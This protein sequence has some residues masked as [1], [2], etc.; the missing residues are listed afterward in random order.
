MSQMNDLRERSAA[1]ARDNRDLERTVDMLA[2]LIA[3]VVSVSALYI[4]RDIFVPIA[5][6]V[7]LSFVLS[8]PVLWLRRVGLP[9]VAA[10]M[11]VVFASLFIAFAVS[12]ALTRQV[13]DLAVDLPR[14]QTTIG[15]KINR[16]RDM[17]SA[18]AI[19]E[20]AAA[21]LKSLATLGG[22]RAN[23]T[24]KPSSSELSGANEDHPIPVEVREPAP[25]PFALVRTIVGTALSPLETAAIVV[26]FV[27]F[28][29]LQREDLRDRFVRL[30][31][32]GDLQRTTVAMDD[33]ARRLS[34]YFLA[35][36]TINAAFGLAV[37]GGLYAIGVPSPILF[38]IIGF[39]MRFVPYVGP[40][41]AGGFPVALAAAVDPGWALAL[42]TLA[43][44]IVLEMLVGNLIEPLLYG[45]NTGLSPIAVVV[46]ATFWTWLWGS[47][48]LVLSTPLTV[49]L[50]VIGRHVKQLTFLDVIF[51][52]APALTPVEHFYQRLLV[53]DAVEITEGAERFL[54]ANSL[55][56][57]YD[58]VALKGLLMAS[59]DLTRGALDGKR[60]EQIKAT[61]EEMIENLSDHI[62]E[63]PP[64]TNAPAP[65]A[66]LGQGEG[67]APPLVELPLENAPPQ[68]NGPR[69]PVLCI[70]VGSALDEAAAALLAQ[71]LEKHGLEAKIEPPELLTVGGILHL[72]GAGAQIICLS[73]LCAEV[74]AARMRYAIRRLR[75]RLPEARIAAAFWLCDPDRADE[76]CV[77]TKAD[78]CVTRLAD[79]VRFCVAEAKAQD[80]AD[81]P[82]PADPR[83]V[84]ANGAS[85]T[86]PLAGA[87]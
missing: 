56:A 61:L 3:A 85:G 13:S 17:V 82:A 33:A 25:S 53:G 2:T 24:A 28:I 76:L 8:Q 57:Y 44:F 21:E 68:P 36:T 79:A 14:Y 74:N 34:R 83:A 20:K 45:R 65:L 52:D 69:K 42:K 71:L 64:V 9:R 75:R 5:I 27:I 80:R 48:G 86:A 84:A 35:Q 30:V 26:I 72:S 4:A 49:C 38:G 62:D 11:I 50:V 73:Y 46:S 81:A 39:M 31:G 67:L 18:N 60:Q 12:A 70:A 54:K 47:I 78:A 58:E 22:I 23:S 29:L 6:A 55:A 59:A 66:D 43:F 63:P 7:L 1:P 10:V 37:T 87:A 40:I 51:G 16:L 15:G 41:I 77:Q 19:F 32:R